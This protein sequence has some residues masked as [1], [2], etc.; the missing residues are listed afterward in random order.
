MGIR[1][2]SR[3]FITGL[4]ALA[5]LIL[6]AG[7]ALAGTAKVVYS[8]AGEEDGEYPSTDLV[9]DGAGNLYGTT[10]QGGDFGGGTVFQLS[11][12]GNT[13]VHT[14]L[15]SFTGGA[16]GGQPYG[17]VTLDAQGN[18][19]GAAVI[20][21][22][23]GVCVEDGC[24]VAYKLT[25]NG[26]T[27]TQTV[28]HDF[29]GGDDGYGPGAGVT[30][31]KNGNLYGMTPT[32][33]AY[34][35]GTIY[36]LRVDGQGNWK[37]RVIHAFTGGADGGA[38]SAGRL[39]PDAN[40]NLYGVA[41]V[42][43]AHGAGTAFKLTHGPGATWTFRTL[44]AFNGS[45]DAGFPY[46]AL[47]PDNAGNLYG[48]TYYDGAN[49]LGTVYRLSFRNGAWHERVLYSFQ[50]GTDGASP[51]S[52]VVFDQA[53]DLYGTTSEGGAPGC[54]CGTIFKL[55]RG[56]DGIWG[57][58]VAYA[59]TGTPDGAFPYNGMVARPDGAFYGT[60][61]HG[62]DDDEGSVYGFKP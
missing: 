38:A 11:R 17:G 26:G 21:G 36:E 8:F 14:V 13:W 37:E 19:Y 52:N 53:G 32:G 12:S 31:N 50:G 29:T 18:L 44:Y 1:R 28:I 62:G 2:V 58:S 49:D 39:L 45:P 5:A 51:I 25:N 40:G 54:G 35:L 7:A 4:A 48:T 10:V 27:W 22:T 47:V 16:D 55:S 23:G 46:G 61:V 20:G 42:G 43:G 30:L 3:S 34:G 41:T 60:T 33:G 57:E 6:V 59:F 15:Y 9:V 56:P 24:G